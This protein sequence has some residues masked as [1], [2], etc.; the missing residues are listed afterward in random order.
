MV[1]EAIAFCPVVDVAFDPA[2]KRGYVRGFEALEIGEASG[3]D[4]GFLEVV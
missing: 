1:A 2:F 3:N 4:S